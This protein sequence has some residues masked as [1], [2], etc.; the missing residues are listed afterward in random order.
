MD[1]SWSDENGVCILA[2]SDRDVY[3]RADAE[4]NA[5]HTKLASARKL[6]NTREARSVTG[7]EWPRRDPEMKKG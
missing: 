7:H 3:G 4:P 2:Q 1:W 5:C 6:S